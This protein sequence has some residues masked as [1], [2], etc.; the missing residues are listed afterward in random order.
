MK[1]KLLILSLFMASL[2]QGQNLIQN[3]SFELFTTTTPNSWTTLYGSTSKE[4]TIKNEGISSLKGVPVGDPINSVLPTFQLKQEFTLSDTNEYTLKFDYY[5]P[6]VTPSYKNISNLFYEV[7]KETTEGAYFAPKSPDFIVKEYGVWKT[8]TY[9]FKIAAFISPTTSVTMAL[10]FT[11]GSQFEGNSIYFDNISITKKNTL[12]TSTFN[13][14]QNPIEYIGKDEI[15]L[16]SE[17]KNSSYVIYSLDGKAVKR[18]NNNT[19]ENIEISG[20]NKGVY[21]LKL[22]NAGTSVKFIKQ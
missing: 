5:I 8:V 16:S 15:K 3:G 12:S 11:A 10:Y 22:S 20:L 13:E 18:V 6:V 7:K 9:D 1:T 17:Y 14:K 21:L 4:E 19:S 2:T